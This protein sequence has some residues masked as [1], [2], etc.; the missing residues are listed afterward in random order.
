MLYPDKLICLKDIHKRSMEPPPVEYNRELYNFLR[1]T[2]EK[3]G[4]LFY[5]LDVLGEGAAGT[6]YSAS[7]KPKNGSEDLI[8]LKEQDRTPYCLNEIEALK[9]LRIEM[10]EGRLPGYYI[11]MYDTFS[12]GKNR[13]IVLDYAD[14]CLDDYL[15]DNDLTSVEFLRVF[16]HIANAVSKL[17]ERRFNHGDLWSENVMVKWLPDQ[18]DIP[19]RERKFYIK[20]ID[21]DSAF[22]ARS[23]IKRPSYGGAE[24]FRRKFILG[25]DMNRFFDSLIY[26]YNSYLRKKAKYV[27][28]E[29]E[30]GDFDTYNIIYPQ[31]IIDFI[32]SLKPADPNV[33]DDCPNISGEAVKQAVEECAERL[34]LTLFE[35]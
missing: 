30:E 10:L 25:Y 21:Y 17:E 7:I 22:K 20:L 32:H 2:K 33:F 5:D 3:K 27:Q 6:T 15:V 24:K 29:G 1:K 14:K 35:P 34:Q 12:S 8:V 9:Y 18:E 28:R 23:E 13:Y 31:E 11:F 4:Y 16:W 19:E 26:A